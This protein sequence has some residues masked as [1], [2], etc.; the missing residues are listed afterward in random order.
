MY[1]LVREKNIS[2]HYLNNK[3]GIKDVDIFEYSAILPL[4]NKK[5]SFAILYNE[6]D[7]GG[8]LGY[9]WAE[10]VFIFTYSKKINETFG[11]GINY[12]KIDWGINWKDKFGI[13][14]KKLSIG[15]KL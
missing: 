2:Y 15:F 3:L 5:E 10:K 1:S 8:A 4:K 7:F 6:W 11:I 14:H 9:K 12:K 13:S